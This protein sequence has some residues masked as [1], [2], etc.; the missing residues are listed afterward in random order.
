M[1][2]IAVAAAPPRPHLIELIRPRLA[3]LVPSVHIVAEGLLGAESTIDFVCV[4][5]SGRIVLIL[6]GD[7]GEDLELVGRALAQRA[8]VQ[9]RVRDWVQ[10]A[11]SL[12][13]RRGAGVRIVLLCASLR[14]ETRAAAA[15][16]GSDVISLARYRCLRNGADIHI[17]L[18]PFSGPPTATLP[19]DAGQRSAA[20]PP[21]FRT[22]LTDED[23]GL[24]PEERHNLE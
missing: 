23:L 1:A 20:A 3:E 14:P 13:A 8:W 19:V 7:E 16:I 4:E 9:P 12:G 5:P 22:G 17:L 18:E 6:L 24:S 2:D 11:P 10:L 15:A 21:A